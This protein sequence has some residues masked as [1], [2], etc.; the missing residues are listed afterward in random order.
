MYKVTLK[1]VQKVGAQTGRSGAV[2]EALFESKA[3]DDDFQEVKRARG[4][5][6]IIPCRK[7]RSRPNQS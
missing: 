3:Q 1:A 7:P 2:N 4:I 5:S 6:L